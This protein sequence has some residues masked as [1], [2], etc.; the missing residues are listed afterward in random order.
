MAEYTLELPELLKQ[1]EVISRAAGKAILEVYNREDFEMQLKGDDSPLT[2]ADLASEVVIKAGLEKLADQYVIVSEESIEVPFSDRENAH[3][4]W[5]VDPLDGTKEFLKRNDE[6]CVCIALIENGRPILG[7][8]HAPVTGVSYVGI[9]GGGV[10]AIDSNGEVRQLAPKP[11]SRHASATG[12]RFGVSRSHLNQETKDYL[13]N[14][15]EPVQAP[16][17]SALKFCAIADDT[18]DAYPRFGPTMEWDTAA[19]DLLV[20]ETGGE[21]LHA[22]TGD[23]LVYNKPNLLNPFFIAKG[24]IS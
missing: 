14:F 23:K 24:W 5:M 11:G 1:V 3:R 7:I 15:K 8:I 21:L 16:M 17:G 12:L 10:Q 22:E 19:G 9:K 13:N 20:H 6:F 4:L 18:M 2:A